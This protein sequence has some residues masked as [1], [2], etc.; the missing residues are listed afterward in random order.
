MARIIVT[1]QQGDRPDADVL[2]DE[3]IHPDHLCDDEAAAQLIERIGWAVTDA[4]DVEHRPRNRAAS[5]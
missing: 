5:R 3:W 1:T 4:D 2:L